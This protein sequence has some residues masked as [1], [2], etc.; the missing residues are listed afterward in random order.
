MNEIAVLRHPPKPVVAQQKNDDL[1][2]NGGFPQE[3]AMVLAGERAPC[4]TEEDD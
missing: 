2:K 4:R 1:V 3:A